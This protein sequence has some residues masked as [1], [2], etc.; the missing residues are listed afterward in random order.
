VERRTAGGRCVRR[1]AVRPGEEGAQQA[2]RPR[3]GC[4]YSSQGGAPGGGS[5]RH[6]VLSTRGGLEGGRC[7]EEARLEQA[8]GATD[9]A[10]PPS[11]P[12]PTMP[13][14]TRGR[15]CA[16][17]CCT[18]GSP[19]KKVASE[20]RAAATAVASS[21]VPARTRPSASLQRGSQWA[22]AEQAAGGH[23]EHR[24]TRPAAPGWLVAHGCAGG[25]RPP[26]QPLRTPGVAGAQGIGHHGAGGSAQCIAAHIRKHG[27]LRAQRMRGAVGHHYVMHVKADM[28]ICA[29][30]ECAGRSAT[31][32]ARGGGAQGVAAWGREPTSMDLQGSCHDHCCCTP[33]WRATPTTPTATSPLGS[34]PASSTIVSHSHH[35]CRRTGGGACRVSPARRHRPQQDE[36]QQAA[37]AWGSPELAL[38][39]AVGQAEL[40]DAALLQGDS[41][42]RPLPRWAAPG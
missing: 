13:T 9:A 4:T 25:V 40:G 31:N 22:A 29:H 19:V 6:C 14:A 41:R 15:S 23:L 39:R 32:G 3:G 1:Q 11:C 18:A 21:R 16:S 10:R 36:A 30:S 5:A 35:S 37:A 28:D 7:Q 12:S 17:S 8:G 42:C 26:G 2:V 20:R 38:P 34:V 27:H 33:T 24:A